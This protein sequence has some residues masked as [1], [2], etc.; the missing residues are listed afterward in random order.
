[1]PFM[2]IRLLIVGLAAATVTFS[3]GAIADDIYKW[4]DENG[5]VHYEDRPSGSPT[6]EIIQMSYNRTNRGAVQRRTESRRDAQI[7]LHNARTQVGED[8]QTAA[9]QRA[10]REER[11]IRCKTYRAKLQTML[12]S[13]RLYRENEN[14]ERTY[15][16]EAAKVA[17]RQN[18]EE[19]IKE[20]CDT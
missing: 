4:T 17:A 19:L 14:G 8:R 10:E 12:Q 16:D 3:G 7:S 9:E 13:R 11:K 2:D 6:E 20:N 18:A 15:L 5:G 1:M